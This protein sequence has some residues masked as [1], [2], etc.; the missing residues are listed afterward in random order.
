MSVSVKL[1]ISQTLRCTLQGPGLTMCSTR[2]S[3]THLFLITLNGTALLGY[4]LPSL[5]Q[6]LPCKHMLA[7]NIFVDI[8][9]EISKVFAGQFSHPNNWS[10]E[11]FLIDAFVGGKK[12]SESAGSKS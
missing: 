10:R 8:E 4:N 6:S 1:V 3:I 11:V 2:I 9:I 12:E 5:R 7:D